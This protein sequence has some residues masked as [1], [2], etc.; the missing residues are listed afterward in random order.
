MEEFEKQRFGK[1]NE[2]LFRLVMKQVTV[3]AIS[4]PFMEF[5]G[6]IGIA[7]IIWYGG[8]QVFTGVSTPGR[9]FSFL[10]ALLLLYEPVRRLSGINNMIQEGMAAA[11]AFS[12]LLDTEP[13][14]EDGPDAQ[15]LRPIQTAIEAGECDLRL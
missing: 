12:K 6:G 14:I 1:E 10:T 7:V 3:R 4:S 9:F 13:E 2:R 15:E 11:S 5:L 8:Y